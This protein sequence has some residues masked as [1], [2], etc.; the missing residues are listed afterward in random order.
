VDNYIIKN[1]KTVL[2]IIL[3]LFFALQAAAAAAVTID[4]STFCVFYQSC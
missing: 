1:I 4:L 3:V 2:K